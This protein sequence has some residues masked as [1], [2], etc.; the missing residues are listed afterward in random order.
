MLGIAV[1]TLENWRY[2]RTGVRGPRFARIGRKI[3]YPVDGLRE[4]LDAHTVH[5][6]GSRK[7]AGA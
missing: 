3:V 6:A 2:E 1:G 4:Y 7:G 5:N